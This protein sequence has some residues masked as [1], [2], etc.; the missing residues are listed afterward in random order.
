MSAKLGRVSLLGPDNKICAL[1]LLAVLGANYVF[2][3]P[4]TAR[5]HHEKDVNVPLQ[6]LPDLPNL[7]SYP[8][9]KFLGGFCNTQPNG[10]RSYN[11]FL[12]TKDDKN[13][14][15]KW[16][17]TELQSNSWTMDPP[18]RNPYV[19]SASNH[20]KFCTVTTGDPVN[21]STRITVMFMEAH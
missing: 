18:S 10:T 13:K 20:Q 7:A 2:V 21:G 11:F 14:I 5:G 17:R 16:Y 3:S 9:S 15:I 8:N 19:V 1:F 4:V 12:E 6:K